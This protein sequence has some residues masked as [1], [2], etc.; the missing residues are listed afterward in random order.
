MPILLGNTFPLSLIRR[1][2][3]IRPARLAELHERTADQ[4]VVSFW[5]HANTSAA[6]EAILGFNPTPKTDRPAVT[7]DENLL[8]MLEGMTFYEVWVLSPDYVQGLRPLAGKEVTPA[9][10]TGWQVLRIT[11]QPT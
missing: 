9:Q 8:P 4:G 7:L 5:G 10:I 6:A 1:C 11:F 2:V 3:A